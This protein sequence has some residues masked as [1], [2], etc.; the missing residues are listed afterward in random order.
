MNKYLR[1]RRNFLKDAMKMA[2]AATLP[3]M[4]L[5]G[6]AYARADAEQFVVFVFAWGGWSPV[7][8]TDPKGD[9]VFP[10]NDPNFHRP[11]C[12]Y[13]AAD[14]KTFGGIRVAPVNRDADQMNK[15]NN[16][17]QKFIAKHHRNLLVVNGID[18]KTNG[19][20]PGANTALRGTTSAN[21]PDF[22]AIFAHE[23]GGNMPMPALG[24]VFNPKGLVTPVNSRVFSNIEK[25]DNLNATSGSG[26]K[27]LG[28]DAFDLVQQYAHDLTNS[29][30]TTDATNAEIAMMEVY[31]ATRS[32]IEQ[33]TSVL[34]YL[35]ELGANSEPA[36]IAAAFASGNS[37]FGFM[38]S[39]GFDT[40]GNGPM[41][42]D[43][44]VA[45]ANEDLM[46]NLDLLWSELERHNIAERTTVAV[47][48][49]LG[50]PPAY[51]PDTGG[52]GHYS[53]TAYWLMG[54]NVRGNRT[55]GLTDFNMR[56][57][58]LNPKTGEYLKEG[59]VMES[60][61][62]QKYLRYITGL[63]GT[64]TDYTYDLKTP[65]LDFLL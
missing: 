1:T 11:I 8:L 41:A 51:Y 45:R 50:T 52:K 19:H 61:H 5:S 62:I 36:R 29:L 26:K 43:K 20:V 7:D 34:D 57:Q 33:F 3:S 30:S 31:G 21:L 49:D 25:L 28:D 64:F 23:M 59:V 22:G 4:F 35:P 13:S 39:G 38:G 37:C 42:H 55:V 17:V 48:S 47:V 24:R 6:P 10:N 18:H 40:H 65:M 44:P 54:K 32:Q 58:P 53:H 27:I 46:N 60:R 12:N 63:E 15:D 14:I 56:A 2:S 16:V 9:H